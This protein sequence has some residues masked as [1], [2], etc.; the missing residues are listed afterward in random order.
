MSKLDYSKLRKQLQKEGEV[1]S[2]Y[3][4]AGLQLFYE[5]YSWQQ[6]TVKSRMISIA[7]TMHNTHHHTTQTGGKVMNTLKVRLGSKY[8]STV[9]GMVLSHHPHQ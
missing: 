8:S 2:W 6:E 5:K 3:T 4:T 7:K 1:P 9:C